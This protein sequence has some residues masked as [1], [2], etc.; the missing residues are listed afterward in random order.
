MCTYDC[1]KDLGDVIMCTR[2]VHVTMTTAVYHNVL[3]LYENK[4]QPYTNQCF[5]FLFIAMHLEVLQLFWLWWS[6]VTMSGSWGFNCVVVEESSPR[7]NA[8][9]T[10]HITTDLPASLDTRK[11]ENHWNNYTRKDTSFCCGRTE[12][13]NISNCFWLHFQ[14]GS[15]CSM[16]WAMCAWVCLECKPL[17]DQRYILV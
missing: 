11:H 1:Q 3:R 8:D 14:L 7:F 10:G 6:G 17:S 2:A 13:V 12:L 5:L 9:P 16:H 15:S 4:L